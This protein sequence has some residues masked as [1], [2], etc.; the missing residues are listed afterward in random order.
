MYFAWTFAVAVLVCSRWAD[1]NAPDDGR[2]SGIDRLRQYFRLGYG[3][4]LW[5]AGVQIDTPARYASV[6]CLKITTGLLRSL[7][8]NLYLPAYFDLMGAAHAGFDLRTAR[9]IALG[10]AF[11]TLTDWAHRVSSV[12]TSLT[13]ADIAIVGHLVIVCVDYAVALPLLI[14]PL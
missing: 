2:F 10:H 4:H 5:V 9:V 14:A 1:A 3:S 13:Q 12:V 7:I 8:D 11:F 6:I